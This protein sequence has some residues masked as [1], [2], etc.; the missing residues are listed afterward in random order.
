MWAWNLLSNRRRKERRTKICWAWTI[1]RPCAGQFTCYLIKT[2]MLPVPWEKMTKEQ[3]KSHMLIVLGKDIPFWKENEKGIINIFFT[4][5]QDSWIRCFFITEK[6]RLEKKVFK[7]LWILPLTPNSGFLEAPN[8]H[9]HNSQ[10]KVVYRKGQVS[11]K[12]KYLSLSST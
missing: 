6:G 4:H 5:T 10:L 3:G 7:S 8:P 1:V 2:G 11:A 9:P 12:G